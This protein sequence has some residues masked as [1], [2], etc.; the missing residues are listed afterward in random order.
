[1]STSPRASSTTSRPRPSSA[2]R[3]SGSTGSA[4]TPEPQPDVELHSLER[5]RRRARLACAGMNVRPVDDGRLRRRCR[6][7]SREDEEHVLGQASQI[8]VKRPARLARRARDARDRQLAVRG[9]R[10]SSARVGWCDSAPGGD[11]GVGVGVVR[12][13]WKGR[14]LGARARRAA[15]RRARARQGAA[16]MHQFAL[17]PRTRPRAR[18]SRGAR[19]PRRPPLLRRWR[20]S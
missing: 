17:R 11:V 20:S 18:A 6:R 3:R 12:P 15:P 2:C 8:A 1:M 9:R 19:L 4:R 16:R 7:C 14:G 5:A 10:A 13:G